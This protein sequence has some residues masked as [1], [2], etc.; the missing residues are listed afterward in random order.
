[1]LYVFS[2]HVYA[3]LDHGEI[4]SFVTP[5]IALDFGVSPKVLEETFTVS[6]T[7][8]NLILGRSVFKNFPIKL[9]L[10]ATSVN[11]IDMT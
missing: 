8:G 4:L 7:V 2:I 10:K 9:S 3:W 5:Y 11:I 1:M 6:T